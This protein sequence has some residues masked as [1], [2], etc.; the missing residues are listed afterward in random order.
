MLIVLVHM[1]GAAM[2]VNSVPHSVNAVSG[3]P[4]PT[5]FADPPGVGLSPPSVNVLWGGA[6]FIL[7]A[8]LLFGVGE[9]HVGFDVHT[10]LVF[11]AGLLA[12]YGIARHFER[13]AAR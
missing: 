1:L 2:L 10:A 4:F 6:N 9:F 5:P 7:G 12:A 8:L 3:R 13:L 11:A